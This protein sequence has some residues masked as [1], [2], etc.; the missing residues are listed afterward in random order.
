MVRATTQ[1]RAR[2]FKRLGKAAPAAGNGVA[3]CHRTRPVSRREGKYFDQDSIAGGIGDWDGEEA[4][5]RTRRYVYPEIDGCLAGREPFGMEST[6]SG[7]AG[8]ELVTRA[9]AAGFRIEGLYLGTESPDVNVARIHQRVVNATG[10]Y[11]DPKEIPGRFRWS[12]SNLRRRF[13]DFDRLE[14]ADNTPAVEGP[15]VDPVVQ[16]VAESGAITSRRRA[17][18]MA[19]WCE[20]FLRRRGVEAQRQAIDQSRCRLPRVW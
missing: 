2:W 15:L 14:V 19:G 11:V 6:F 4:R 12:L 16:F 8:P 20:E 13:D 18:E 9:M 3:S 1:W 17:G 10:R 5:E 7:R